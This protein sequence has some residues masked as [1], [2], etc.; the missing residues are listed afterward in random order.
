MFVSNGNFF[1]FSF[2]ASHMQ[3]LSSVFFMTRSR[4]SDYNTRISF[5]M[6]FLQVQNV[7]EF[8]N[9][10]AVLEVSPKG[11]VSCS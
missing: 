5:R 10:F 9:V 11:K 2:D 4:A 7:A 1:F 8:G 6:V 3:A